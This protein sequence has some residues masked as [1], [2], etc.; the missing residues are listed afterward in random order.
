M[1]FSDLF[2]AAFSWLAF[3][4]FRMFACS[5]AFWLLHCRNLLHKTADVS[6]MISFYHL[7]RSTGPLLPE[8]SLTQAKNTLL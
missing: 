2:R 7:K 4:P 1:A 6:G 5:L 3:Q 8:P